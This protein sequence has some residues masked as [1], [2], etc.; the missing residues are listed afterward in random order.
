MFDS[1]A[2]PSSSAPSSRAVSSGAAGP[3]A[4]DG[5]AAGSVGAA[6]VLAAVPGLQTAEERAQAL[7][8]AVALEGLSPEASLAALQ[9]LNYDLTM[10]LALYQ[11]MVGRLKDAMEQSDLEK[12][13]LEA[14]KVAIEQQLAAALNGHMD[15]LATAHSM[16]AASGNSKRGWGL[17]G[18]WRRGGANATTEEGEV[19]GSFADTNSITGLASLS[20]SRTASMDLEAVVAGHSSGSPRSA[21]DTPTLRDSTSSSQSAAES[22]ESQQQQ[23]TGGEAGSAGAGGPTTSAT[24]SAATRS[25]SI[26]RVFAQ[27]RA[28]AAARA[29]TAAENMQKELKEVRR[30][31]T[32]VQD[33]NKFLVQNLV[34]IKMELAETQST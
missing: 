20:S 25:T 19:E 15:G 26:G 27:R 17:G 3:A 32:S 18:F 33:E 34:E 4:A 9:Q 14:E 7:M 6:A 5:A 30:Q 8:Q 29:A 12:A 28:S 1:T 21:A 23:Q 10:Q 24:A 13:E 11:Q 31:L 2:S 16:G 22:A